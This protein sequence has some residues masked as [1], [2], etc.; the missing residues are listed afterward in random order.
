[1]WPIEDIVLYFLGIACKKTQ[2]CTARVVGALEEYLL[3]VSQAC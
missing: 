1:M 3:I 2:I